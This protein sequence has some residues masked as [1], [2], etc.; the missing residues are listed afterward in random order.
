MT[1]HRN[2]LYAALVCAVVLLMLN[3]VVGMRAGL[4]D[5]QAL[6]A[7]AAE[8]EKAALCAEYDARIAALEAELEAEKQIEH[9]VVTYEYHPLPVDYENIG[10]AMPESSD[11][12][13]MAKVFWGEYNWGEHMSPE[14]Y[15]QASAVGWDILNMLDAGGYG[16]TIEEVVSY[17]NRFAGYSPNNPVSAENYALAMEILARHELEKIA[18]ADVGRTLPRD[19]LWFTG[20]GYVNTFR[21]AYEGPCERITP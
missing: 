14:N 18:V 8:A 11:A 17:P 9:V 19:F 10:P 3:F 15:G 5:G 6:A 12:V 21:N 4:H 13:I 1:K 2:E 7:E 20:D 16:Q